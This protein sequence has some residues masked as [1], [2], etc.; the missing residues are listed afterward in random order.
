[1]RRLTLSFDNGP[2]PGAR[3]MNVRAGRTDIGSTGVNDRE[4]TPMIRIDG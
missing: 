4:P 2:C 1:M 3:V